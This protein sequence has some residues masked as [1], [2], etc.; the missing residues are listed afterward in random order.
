MHR[1]IRGAWKEARQNILVAQGKQKKFVD[2]RRKPKEKEIA[3][4]DKILIFND[5]L[6]AGSKFSDRWTG[7]YEVTKE[8]RHNVQY[9]HGQQLK[10]AHKKKVK[11]FHEMQEQP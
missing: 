11:I 10:W 4:G 2:Q 1:A 3:V 6:P 5:H 9:Q 8:H 7:P